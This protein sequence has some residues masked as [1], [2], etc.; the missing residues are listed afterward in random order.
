MKASRR[1]SHR[2]PVGIENR[3]DVQGDLAWRFPARQYADQPLTPEGPAVCTR[4]HASL[5]T[6][7]WQYDPQRYLALRDQPGIHEM[8]C[9]GCLRAERRLYEGEVTIRL[10]RGQLSRDDILHLIHNEEAR[11]RF[12]NPSARIAVMDD[13]EDEIYLLTT[14]Q[15]LAKRIG[16]ELYKAYRGTLTVTPLLRERFTRVLWT[17]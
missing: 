2:V 7:H 10:R 1:V 8:L 6:D 4:C 12:T 16:K 9:P 5:E 3:T 13:R 14:T 17:R 15:F 11:E